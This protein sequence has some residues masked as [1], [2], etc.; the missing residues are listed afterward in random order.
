V[1]PN[2]VGLCF[3]KKK[4]RRAGG[5][6]QVVE[7]LPSKLKAPSSNPGTIKKGGKKM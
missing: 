2:P 1:K 7:I 3:Y 4:K 6:A 5:V